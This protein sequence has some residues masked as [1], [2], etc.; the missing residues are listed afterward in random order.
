MYKHSPYDTDVA[1]ELANEKVE[2]E[3]VEE[4]EK[5]LPPLASVDI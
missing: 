5:K 1:S 3:K 4:V 2:E